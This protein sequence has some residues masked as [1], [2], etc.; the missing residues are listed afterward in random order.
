MEGIID[1]DH[2]TKQYGEVWALRGVS[3]TVHPGECF[4]LLGPNGAG[5]STLIRILSTLESP[6]SGTVTLDGLDLQHRQSV[7]RQRIGVALQA[8]GID[9]MMT[10]RE[11][12]ELMGRL[13]GLSNGLVRQRSGALIERFHLETVAN[14]PIRTYSGGMRRRLDLASALV[15][16]P[17]LIVLDE[18]TTG[19]DITNRQ[20]LWSALT[21]LTRDE[22]KTVL[23]TTQYLEEADALCQ[24]VLFIDHGRTVAAGSPDDLKREMG[25]SVIRFTVEGAEDIIVMQ[26]LHDGGL[27]GSR[28][29][30]RLVVRS[31]TPAV[32]V[33]RLERALSHISAQL[34]DLEVQPPS[35]DD[36][37][38]HLTQNQYQEAPL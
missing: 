15:H 5:K 30:D 36:V 6:T 25:Y 24:R 33:R 18:P 37:F 1:V 4:G 2:I 27:H 10:G 26:A 35:L 7:I 9:P 29:N 32:D 11:T 3:F 21:T 12:L 14:R 13:Y 23:L 28:E 19:L 8:T 22:G 16:D 17:T 34:T 20:A 31:A 38:T